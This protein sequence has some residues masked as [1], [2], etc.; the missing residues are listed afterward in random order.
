MGPSEGG[1]DFSQSISEL[2]KGHISKN[3]P[4]QVRHYGSWKYFL[5]VFRQVARHKGPLIVMP[6][7]IIGNSGPNYYPI[8]VRFILYTLWHYIYKPI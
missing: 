6:M 7:D 5:F 8:K 3:S 4:E 1:I 2:H